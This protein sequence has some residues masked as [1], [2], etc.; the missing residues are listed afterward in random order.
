M[1]G[2]KHFR[3]NSE[4][5]KSDCVSVTDIKGPVVDLGRVSKS[6]GD[7]RGTHARTLVYHEL[8]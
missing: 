3:G 1:G 5:A 8:G 6:A 7:S 4:K 2:C